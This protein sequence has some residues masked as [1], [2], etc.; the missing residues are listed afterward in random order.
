MMTHDRHEPAAKLCE[1]LPGYLS[2][3][4]AAY[5]APLR[6]RPLQQRS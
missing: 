1:I 4:E 5:R 2:S 6:N 3:A